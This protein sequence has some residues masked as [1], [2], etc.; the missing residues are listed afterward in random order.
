MLSRNFAARAN[1][2]MAAV[3]RVGKPVVNKVDRLAAVNKVVNRVASPVA[4]V[5]QVSKAAVSRADS[6]EAKLEGNTQLTSAH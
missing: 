2:Y 6:L 1:F 5:E 3:S 4:A